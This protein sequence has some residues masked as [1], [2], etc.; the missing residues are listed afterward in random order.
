MNSGFQIKQQEVVYN[1]LLAK[2]VQYLSFKFI[3]LV[4]LT[5]SSG[6]NV[7][8]GQKLSFDRDEA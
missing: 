7:I 6:L 2:L 4:K 5:H 1:Q 3:S 8:T